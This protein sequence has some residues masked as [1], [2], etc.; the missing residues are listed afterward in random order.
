MTDSQAAELLLGLGTTP[1]TFCVNSGVLPPPGPETVLSVANKERYQY[2]YLDHIMIRVDD[3]VS[4]TYNVSSLAYHNVL[5]QHML[6]MTQAKFYRLPYRENF[7]HIDIRSASPTATRFFHAYCQMFSTKKGDFCEKS[8]DFQLQ[9]YQQQGQVPLDPRFVSLRLNPIT[10]KFLNLGLIKDLNAQPL[11]H[12]SPVLNHNNPATMV[13]LEEMRSPGMAT[14]P[15][16]EEAP[17]PSTSSWTAQPYV[18]VT[19][20]RK[21][22]TRKSRTAKATVSQR[23]PRKPAL[24]AKLRIKSPASMGQ[25]PTTLATDADD[26]LPDG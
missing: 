7:V 17:A 14:L 26:E 24:P 8:L 21:A 2:W 1:D 3:G 5:M 16:R 12:S 4:I 22:R 11:D 10:N 25:S 15:S 23:K 19:P 9:V 6:R 18:N 20:K 13:Q